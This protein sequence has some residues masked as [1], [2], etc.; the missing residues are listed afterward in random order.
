MEGTVRL[1]HRNSLR[2]VPLYLPRDPA[3]PAAEVPAVRSFER[4]FVPDKRI[5]Q[6]E[7]KDAPPRP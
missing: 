2:N 5:L 1:H 4:T 3:I 6:Q 7:A